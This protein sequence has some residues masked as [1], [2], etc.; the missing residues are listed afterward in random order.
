LNDSSRANTPKTKDQKPKTK[1]KNK[2]QESLAVAEISIGKVR[3]KRFREVKR[4][5]V[6]LGR[7]D[8]IRFDFL[9]PGSTMPLVVQPNDLEV[10][11]ASWAEGN[12]E[13]IEA[14][15][16]AHGALLFRG[17]GLHSA[18]EFERCAREICGEL[19]AEYGDLP[20]E[21]ESGAVYQSTPYPANEAILFHNEA[22][23]THR[24]PMKQFFF[25][26][27]AAEQGGE[28]P[29]VDCR[30]VYQALGQR[31]TEQ[32]KR[33]E[34]MYVRNFIPTLDVSWQNFFRTTD[35]AAVE[36]YCRRSS[37][38]FS[39][40]DDGG[41]RT[42]QFCPAIARHPRTNEDIFFNQVQLHHISSLSPAVREAVLASFSEEDLPRNVYHRDGSPIEESVMEEV[43][44]AYCEAAVSFPWRE[45]DMLM[46]DN[47]LVAHSRQPYV[48]QR[49]IVVAMADMCDQRGND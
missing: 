42:R 43:N 16:L 44:R 15:L 19:F 36:A 34:L 26:V 25:C 38:D 11:L 49:K 29:V 21:R 3:G 20:H 8:S 2:D 9:Q 10:D 32:F 18:I 48:G 5:T 27:K 41:L 35:R 40:R 30:K 24:W 13:L 28:T 47:M 39:W 45:G 22:A 6:D 17:F 33:K 23:H 4:R 31:I 7:G 1:T 37:I 12:R 46:L 14:Q